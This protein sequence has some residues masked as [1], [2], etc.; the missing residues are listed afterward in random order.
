MEGE[1]KFE[2][3]ENLKIS[4]VD[5]LYSNEIYNNELIHFDRLLNGNINE[6]E[7]N[8]IQSGGYVI[9]TLEA[10]IWCLLTS[11]NYEEALLKTVNLG[12]DTDTTGAVTG[13]LAGLMYGFKSIPN[14]WISSIVKANEINLLSI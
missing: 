3:Y 6:L 4:V 7:E 9:Q 5:F 13:G 12:G 14:K 10:S 1:D 11:D 8:A 2:I